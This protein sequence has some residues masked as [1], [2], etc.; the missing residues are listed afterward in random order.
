MGISMDRCSFYLETCEGK[1]ANKCKCQKIGRS[2]TS[3]M[4]KMKATSHT[5]SVDGWSIQYSCGSYMDSYLTITSPRDGRSLG[6]CGYYGKN[7]AGG[8]TGNGNFLARSGSRGGHRMTSRAFYESPLTIKSGRNSHFRCNGF[9][10]AAKNTAY[11]FKR[12][13]STIGTHAELGMKMAEQMLTE[14]YALDKAW[15]LARMKD[16]AGNEV[17]TK[18]A[19]EICRKTIIKCSGMPVPDAAAMTACVADYVKVGHE[20]GKSVLKG[21][22]DVVKEDNEKCAWKQMKAFPAKAYGDYFKCDQK[23]LAKNKVPSW[24]RKWCGWGPVTVGI[25]K[26]AIE[27]QIK[28]KGKMRIRF[29]QESHKCYCCNVKGIDNIKI[30]TGGLP[31]RCVADKEMEVFADGEELGNAA[32]NAIGYTWNDD[33]KTAYRFRAPCDTK[34]VGAKVKGSGSGRAG[35]MCSIGDSV[36]TSS[37]WRCTDEKK[38]L[39]GKGW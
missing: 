22:C 34:V 36:V 39:E 1:E 2:F 35:L 17:S 29:F 10:N 31:I 32:K 12:L 23:L 15:S 11:H 3:P 16:P 4:F 24:K 14:Q 21:A 20:E 5:M 8:D 28:A 7:G 27:A 6:L 19:G 30:I 33:F 13:G 25:P 9:A 26:E 37:S 38:D 18:E